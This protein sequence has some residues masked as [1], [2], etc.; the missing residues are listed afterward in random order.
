MVSTHNKEIVHFA[1]IDLLE[2][3]MTYGEKTKRFLEE[4]KKGRDYEHPNSI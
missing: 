2:V 4:K 1:S 3:A